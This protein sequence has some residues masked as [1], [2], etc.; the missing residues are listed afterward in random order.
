MENTIIRLERG[1]PE[2][3]KFHPAIDFVGY[4]NNYYNQLLVVLQ[5]VGNSSLNNS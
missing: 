4:F 2:P 5:R 1:I 3:R